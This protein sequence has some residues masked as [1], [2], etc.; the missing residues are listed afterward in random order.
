MYFNT[1]L[2][3]D[4]AEHFEEESDA[5]RVDNDVQNEAVHWGYDRK[6]ELLY[7]KDDTTRLYCTVA[8]CYSYAICMKI[9]E[10]MGI[11]EELVTHSG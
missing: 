8:K 1:S 9:E 3:H 6:F 4:E 10:C 7:C 5:E 11:G 2:G